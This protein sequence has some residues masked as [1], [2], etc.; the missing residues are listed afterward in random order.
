MGWNWFGKGNKDDNE[1]QS[2]TQVQPEYQT[3]SYFQSFSRS[4]VCRP[5][6]EDDNFLLCKEKVNDGKSTYENQE[7]VP[8]NNGNYR[9]QNDHGN[10]TQGFPRNESL[11]DIQGNMR[12]QFDQFQKDFQHFMTPLFAIPTFF[13]MAQTPGFF[14]D[15]QSFRQER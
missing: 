4:R 2:H 13:N 8:V 14:Q 1:A 7:R 5:D 15:N 6:P 10:G 11:E 12:Q 3:Q 9:K